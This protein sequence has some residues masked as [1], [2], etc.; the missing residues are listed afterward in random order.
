MRHITKEDRTVAALTLLSV[1]ALMS[2]AMLP[3]AVVD[4]ANCWWAGAT[5]MSSQGASW[6]STAVIVFG[7]LYHATVMGAAFGT[8]FGPGVGTSVGAGIG[9]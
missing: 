9:L 1:I 3:G 4:D 8:A 7:G 6:Q 5:Y 2:V